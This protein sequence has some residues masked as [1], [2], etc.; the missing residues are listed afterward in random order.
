MATE[1]SDRDLIKEFLK[2]REEE[3]F[4]LLYRRHTPRLYLFCLRLCKGD[5]GRAEDVVQETW[6]R[7]VKNLERFQWRSAFS[8]WLIGI[9]LNC[10]REQRIV[11]EESWH[12]STIAVEPDLD[13]PLDL[14]S[15]IRRLPD[16]CREVFVLHE[17]EG[18][19]HEEIAEFLKIG[20][21]TS[22]SQLF[23]AR[24]K[25]RSWISG[26]SK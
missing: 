25:L 10:N 23:E 24:K 19:T 11:R 21:G 20:N 26:G 5:R 8:S 1:L 16:G 12:S 7:A 15:L 14:E 3:T 2:H 18:Y 6:I 13:A 9:G 17:I 4:R 22:K